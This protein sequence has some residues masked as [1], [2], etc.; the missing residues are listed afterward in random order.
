MA[1]PGYRNVCDVIVPNDLCSGCGVC[2]GVC[3]VKALNIEWNKYGEYTPFE[4]KGK[5]IDCGLCL[6]VCPFWNQEENEST[7]AK[8]EFGSQEGISQAE[9]TGLYLN[10]FAGYSKVGDQRANAASGGLTTW[11]LEKMLTQGFVDKVGCVL[12]N[13]GPETLFR[14]SLVDDPAYIR[15]ASRSVYYP[16]ELS[17]VISE[18]IKT[19]GKY[20]LVGLPCTIKAIRLAMQS[21][22]ILR[23][24][25]VVLLGLVCGQQKSKFFAEYV[26]AMAGG[27]PSKIKTARFRVKDIT[28]HV[29]DHCFEFSQEENGNVKNGRIYQTEGMDRVWGYDYFKLNACSF[30]DDICAE[31]ADVVF[32]DAVHKKLAHGP[33]GSNFVLVRSRQIRELLLKGRFNDEVFLRPT[34]LWRFLERQRGVKRLKRDE[35]QHRLYILT[36]NNKGGY[37][38]SKRFAPKECKDTRVAGSVELREKMRILS[39]SLY[40][41]HKGESNIVKFVEQEIRPLARQYGYRPLIVKIKDKL[42]RL[43]A[44]NL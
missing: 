44:T 2:V 21:N 12:P 1:K 10:L 40:A 14:Y 30:C 6:K 31:T 3:P 11:L 15:R 42:L 13:N 43:I 33:L 22:E 18:I 5:C 17:G 36:K 7:L 25:I 29:L 39:R 23:K 8:R 41:K 28:R 20:A 37:I 19:E 38:P 32:C 9:I 16:V 24:R 26:C 27:D 4:Q 35:M 34:S